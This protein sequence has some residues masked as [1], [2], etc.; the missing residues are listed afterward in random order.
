MS[1]S[2]FKRLLGV[3]PRGR[4]P[5][6]A[7]ARGSGPEF[8][9]AAQQAVVFED[10]L[11]AALNISPPVELLGQIQDIGRQPVR[12]RNWVPLAMAASLVIAVGVVGLVWKQGRNWD[13]VEDY[14]A[15]H[16]AHDGATL[17]AKAIEAVDRE[18]VDHL[19]AKLHAVADQP[20]SSNIRLIKFCP[21]PDGRG[22]HMV[23]DT[24]QGLMTVILMPHTD[25]NDGQ[26]VEF[27]NMHA[28]LVNLAPGSAAIIG[29]QDQ[30]V[31][32]LQDLVRGSLKTS[33]IGV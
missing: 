20:L 27:Q 2:E 33:V 14:L 18:E 6:T 28:V 15:D 16:Y 1:F 24:D 30:S 29:E 17:V 26:V 22:A 7:Q 10:K 5:G 12:R 19:L 23:V 4:E 3:D 21:T 8:E 25:V 31:D 9:A 13:G 11:E 32:L